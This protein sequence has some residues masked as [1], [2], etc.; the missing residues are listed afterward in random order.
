MDLVNFRDEWGANQPLAPLWR[1]LTEQPWPPP[2]LAPTGARRPLCQQ[3]VAS[4]RILSFPGGFQTGEQCFGQSPA[5]VM[6]SMSQEPVR[7]LPG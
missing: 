3:A 5:M 1:S 2:I 6:R 4:P 7:V